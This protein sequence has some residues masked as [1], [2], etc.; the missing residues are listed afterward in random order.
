MARLSDGEMVPM[1]MP[2]GCIAKLPEGFQRY[3][4]SVQVGSLPWTNG[5][6][7]KAEGCSG[8]IARLRSCLLAVAGCRFCCTK[9]LL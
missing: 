9:T 1:T 2:P 8:H 4:A 5:N 3:G 6:Y 7:G